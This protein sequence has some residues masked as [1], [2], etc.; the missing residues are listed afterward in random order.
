MKKWLGPLVSVFLIVGMFFGTSN[1][2]KLEGY[3]I[4]PAQGEEKKDQTDPHMIQVLKEIQKKL[5]EWLTKL[6]DRI[7]REDVTRFEV[8]FLEVLRN[9]L[10]WTKE[11]VD[12]KIQSE[13]GN[14]IKK[15]KKGREIFRETR[16]DTLSLCKKG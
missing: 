15:Q 12:A 9:I 8:R 5:D 2:A 16:Q 7:E 4:L 1:G 10:E 13:T 3:R 14:P 6:N 11:K